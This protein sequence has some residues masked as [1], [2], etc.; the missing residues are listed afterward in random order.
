MVPCMLPQ[1]GIPDVGKNSR[2]EHADSLKTNSLKTN[3]E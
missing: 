3:S 1:T 2:K